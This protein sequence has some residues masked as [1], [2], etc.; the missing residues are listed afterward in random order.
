MDISPENVAYAREQCKGLPVE[1]VLSD[2]LT[3]L[4]EYKG[5]AFNGV[6]LDSLDTDRPGHQGHCLA[7]AQAALAHLAGDGVI[8]LD[9]NHKD[10]KPVLALPWLLK[11]GLHV[12]R[13]GYQVLLGRKVVQPTAT[14]FSRKVEKRKP[15]VVGDEIHLAGVTASAMPC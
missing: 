11:S 6:Y 14:P 5:P 13:S 12:Q 1:V 10:G 15:A 9:D 2:S 3:F 4:K 7:E 8:L